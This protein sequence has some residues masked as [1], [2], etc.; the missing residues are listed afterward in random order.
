M[1]RPAL[2]RAFCGQRIAQRQSSDFTQAAR[3]AGGDQFL[4]T[5]PFF[6]RP[7][8]ASEAINFGSHFVPPR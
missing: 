8:A 7:L 5:A 1:K 2:L 3:L 4:L 6:S